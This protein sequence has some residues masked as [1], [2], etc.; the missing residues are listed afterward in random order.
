MN[1]HER[2]TQIM[3][4]FKQLQDMNLGIMGYEELDRF[5]S[6]CTTFIRTGTAIVGTIPVLGTKRI[7]AYR[8]N[9]EVVECTLKYDEWI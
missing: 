6:I 2:T 3:N 8:F 9:N 4:I 7:I 5:K 1:I